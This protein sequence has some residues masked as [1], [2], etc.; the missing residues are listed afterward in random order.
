MA[1]GLV[2]HIEIK[3]EASHEI[4]YK[5]ECEKCNYINEMGK[6]YISQKANKIIKL[7]GIKNI[8]RSRGRLDD[9]I[10]SIPDLQVIINEEAK[11]RL[12]LAIG[13]LKEIIT[14]QS[15]NI[16][17]I[18]D[19]LML[20]LYN[21]VFALGMS[22]ANCKSSQSWYPAYCHIKTKIKL[23]RN[24]AIG[25]SFVSFV[26]TIIIIGYIENNI[27][28]QLLYSIIIGIISALFGGLYG[29]LK[30]LFNL[31]LIMKHINNNSVIKK[32]IVDW[33]DTNEY[34]LLN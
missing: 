3:C 15:N 29:Y 8:A 31:K 27:M 6:S 12:K 30:Y 33:K 13:K 17:Y 5:Y 18:D 34:I 9:I 16:V 4:H 22:C 32:P 26:L 2:N 14:Y 1:R 10:L 11:N 23:I 28:T 24:Y 20:K 7:G 19:P 25:F 21:E